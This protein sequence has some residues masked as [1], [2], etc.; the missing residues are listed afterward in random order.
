MI[1]KS[2]KKWFTHVV[3]E[4]V[5][6]LKT[7]KFLYISVDP[8]CT[9]SFDADFTEDDVSIIFHRCPSLRVFILSNTFVKDPIEGR[10]YKR[11]KSESDKV[12]FLE[13]Y[14]NMDKEWGSCFGRSILP[15]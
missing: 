10:I 12:E 4:F 8:S 15:E 3:A 9:A 1:Y 7:L 6:V 5:E 11:S 14:V 13:M 2:F